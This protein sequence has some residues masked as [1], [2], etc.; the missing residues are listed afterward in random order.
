[1]CCVL[2]SFLF[3]SCS[4]ARERSR[5]Q[6]SIQ[7]GLPDANTR[8]EV[9]G[10]YAKQLSAT[11][12][13]T[14]ATISAGMSGRDMKVHASCYRYCSPIRHYRAFRIDDSSVFAL[15]GLWGMHVAVRPSLHAHTARVS[16]PILRSMYAMYV[17]GKTMYAENRGLK[18]RHDL[19]Q[20]EPNHT[21]PKRTPLPPPIPLGRKLAS[22][23]SA[24]GRPSLCGGR[25]QARC[26]L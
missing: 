13:E 6:L 16:D 9:F 15:D 11:D 24:A 7:F 10:L 14:L 2:V 25:R 21:H 12:L 23:P 18:I 26:H 19:D 8:R 22:T 17:C 1:M 5:F 3:W 4:R 20:Q